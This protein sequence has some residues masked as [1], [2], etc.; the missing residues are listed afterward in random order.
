MPLSG[1]LRTVSLIL[2]LADAC[3]A[4]IV[5]SPSPSFLFCHKLSAANQPSL[6]LGEVAEQRHV[7]NILPLGVVVGKGACLL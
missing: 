2:S 7:E 4:W 5:S 1:G 3:R 6:L